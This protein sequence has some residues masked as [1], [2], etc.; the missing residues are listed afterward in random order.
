MFVDAGV[1]IDGDDYRN[2]LL[3]QKLLPAIRQISGEF[4]IFSRTVP[5]HTGHVTP[6]ISWNVTHLH[7]SRQICGRRIG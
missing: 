4:F 7:S 1:K 3:S 2:V 5:R 6:S